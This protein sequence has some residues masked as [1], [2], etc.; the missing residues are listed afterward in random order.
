MVDRLLTRTQTLRLLRYWIRR[1]LFRRLRFLAR[2][3]RHFPR[4]YLRRTRHRTGRGLRAWPRFPGCGGRVRPCRSWCI[5]RWIGWIYHGRGTVLERVHG[6]R[7]LYMHHSTCQG[8][9]CKPGAGNHEVIRRAMDFTALSRSSVRRL[10]ALPPFAAMHGFIHQLMPMIRSVWYKQH[11]G[12]PLRGRG[13]VGG[14][15][16]RR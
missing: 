15:C 3:V 8:D 12:S 5:R 11:A 6:H 16:T 2:M 9:Q 13:Y 10:S 1:M 4:C 7:F 14:I